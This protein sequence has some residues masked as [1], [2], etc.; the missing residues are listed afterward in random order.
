MPL[1]NNFWMKVAALCFILTTG[2]QTISHAQK[3]NEGTYSL[4]GYNAQST[5]ISYIGTINIKKDGDIYKLQWN[6]GEQKQAGVA[7][8]EGGILSVGYMDTTVGGDQDMGVVS[9]RVLDNGNLEG[10][11][12]SLSSNHTGK[13]VL[14][15]KI[16]EKELV[17]NR[18]NK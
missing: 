7:I 2:L 10:K 12:C 13:E 9:Y 11:W 4:E 8:L 16:G 17:P 18:G 3:L 14:T 1:T 15:W 6:I 5:S